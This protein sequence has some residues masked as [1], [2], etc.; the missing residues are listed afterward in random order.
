[1]SLD[2]LGP[3][4]ALD[5]VLGSQAELEDRV[6]SSVKS[7]ALPRGRLG[8]LEEHDLIDAGFTSVMTTDAGVTAPEAGQLFVK[9][10]DGKMLTL[11][12]RHHP[13]KLRLELT[14]LM[15]RLRVWAGR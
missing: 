8:P 2:Q 9:R 15:D 13:A 11:A 1:M 10:R 12:G 5:E 3:E 7:T 14:G 4:E 6:G